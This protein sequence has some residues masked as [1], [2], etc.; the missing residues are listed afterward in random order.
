MNSF[1]NK[2]TNDKNYLLFDTDKI[3]TQNLTKYLIF[4]YSNTKIRFIGDTDDYAKIN[5]N[6]KECDKLI[7]TGK[8]NKDILEEFIKRIIDEN[9]PNILLIISLSLS[10]TLILTTPLKLLIKNKQK[11]PTL[12]SSKNIFMV[13]YIGRNVFDHIFIKNQLTFMESRMI[14][15]MYLNRFSSYLEV[16]KFMNRIS[17]DSFLSVTN[18]EDF[19]TNTKRFIWDIVPNKW[20]VDKIYKESITEISSDDEIIIYI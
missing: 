20:L 10:M 15:E 14:Y 17:Y 3:T 4:K 7:I 6:T 9:D 8:I 19:S 5:I 11:F 16:H 13:P 2:I 1:F 12:F 18:Y